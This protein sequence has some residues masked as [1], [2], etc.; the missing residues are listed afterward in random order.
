[1]T[2]SLPVFPNGPINLE[3]FDHMDFKTIL[4]DIHSFMNVPRKKKESAERCRGRSLLEPAVFESYKHWDNPWAILNA[5]LEKGM[6]VLDCG[7][8]RGILQFYLALKGVEVFSI[9]IADN[10]SKTIKKISRFLNSVGI[11]HAIDPLAV[12]RKLNKKYG[13]N[14]SFRQES[15]DNLSFPDN[16][17]DRIFSISVIEHMTDEV[18]RGSVM[19]MER[20]LKPGGRLLLTFDFHPEEDD[21]IIGFTENDIKMKVLNA[22]ALSVYGNEP[23]FLIP[24]WEGY[25]QKVNRHFH[26]VNPNTSFGIVLQKGVKNR[27]KH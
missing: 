2:D 10:R 7:S 13:V 25:L 4:D 14:V 11:R 21:S 22:C 15:A 8:G 17:F 16:H 26:T 20:V 12:H 19:E 9:D 6:K 27:K 24:D 3:H 18:I 1:M 23:D 5:G